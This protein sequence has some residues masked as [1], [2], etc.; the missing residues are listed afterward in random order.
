MELMDSRRARRFLSATSVVFTTGISLPALAALTIYTSKSVTLTLV[1]VFSAL[2]VAALV[3]VILL[4]MDMPGAGSSDFTEVLEFWRLFS[5]AMFKA[6]VASLGLN[7]GRAMWAR[8]VFIVAATLSWTTLAI[9][10][11]VRSE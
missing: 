8:R 9:V 1:F 2:M 11:I 5:G 3:A 10:S 7:I 4:Y 6:A